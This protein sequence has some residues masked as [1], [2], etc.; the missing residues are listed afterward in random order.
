M[1]RRKAP[2]RVVDPCPSPRVDPRP[3][4]V[5]IRCPSRGYLAR[6]PHVAVI[7][8]GLPC[9][10]LVEAL[11]ADDFRRNVTSGDRPLVATLPRERPP[12]EP[13]RRTQREVFV[14]AKISAVE[15]K[16]L[17]RGD[18]IRGA[19]AVRLA[20]AASHRNQRRTALWIDI[21]MVRTRA[22]NRER[23]IRRVDLDDLSGIHPPHLDLQCALHELELP[24]AVIEI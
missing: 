10:E 20:L 9:S 13:F 12:L 14:I 18:P 4:T 16:H 6:N 21:E 24:D 2:W 5:A 1:E 15:T 3:M 7:G 22:R 11:V 23:E 8:D 19:F 17:A